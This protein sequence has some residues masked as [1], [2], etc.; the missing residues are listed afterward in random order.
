MRGGGDLES[1]RVVTSAPLGT[2]RRVAR[3]HNATGAMS[4]AS[5]RPAIR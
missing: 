3:G 5:F 1:F 4:A 2:D